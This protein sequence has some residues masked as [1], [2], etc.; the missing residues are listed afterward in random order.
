MSLQLLKDKGT[1]L[2]K[3]GFTCEIWFGPTSDGDGASLIAEVAGRSGAIWKQSAAKSTSTSC[4]CMKRS[5]I[6]AGIQR[7]SRRR[8]IWL[9]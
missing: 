9:R 5:P 2:G 4:W 1:P 3:Q 7:P 6:W 8:P